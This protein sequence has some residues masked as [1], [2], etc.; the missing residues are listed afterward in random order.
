[1]GLRPRAAAIFGAFAVVAC[2]L[3]HP[4]DDY[5]R[6]RG[7]SDAQAPQ[8]DALGDAQT[9]DPKR[10]PE[11]PIQDDGPED[12]SF[13]VAFYTFGLRPPGD[14]GGAP[15][16]DLGYDLDGL[17]S[18]PGPESCAVRPGVKPHCDG[19]RGVDNG[20]AS[21]VEKVALLTG[22]VANFDE[23][24][25]KG[26]FTLLVR[27]RH[28][29]GK[30]NDREVELSVFPSPHIAGASDGDAGG[31]AGDGGAPEGG[32]PPRPVP[33]WDGTDVWAVTPE[34]IISGDPPDYVARFIDT[35]AYVVNHQLVS[36]VDFPLPLGFLVVD[37]RASVFT[38]RVVPDGSGYRLDDATIAGRWSTR[39]LL[40]ALQEVEDPFRQGERLCKDNETYLLLKDQICATADMTSDPTQDGRGAPC[41]AISLASYVSG[42]PALLGPRAPPGLPSPCGPSWT[43]EC[44]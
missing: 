2:S 28:Y 17:C 36:I 24:L 12:T 19:P 14:G 25:Q 40:T 6:G 11:R 29:N 8:P 31:D 22:N 3:L 21:L 26:E 30:A 34:S 37:L 23:K 33:R 20:G 15:L 43:D 7:A 38:A 4:L 44:R 13:V 35:R 9:C 5:E 32:K 39:G 1:M 16:T 27:V 10:W 41:D 18:C 42:R